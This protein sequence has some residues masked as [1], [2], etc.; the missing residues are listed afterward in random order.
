MSKIFNNAHYT[1]D[2]ISLYIVTWLETQ[3]LLK[4]YSNGQEVPRNSIFLPLFGEWKKPIKWKSSFL[5]LGLVINDVLSINR[6][7][8]YRPYLFLSRKL[9]SGLRHRQCSLNYICCQY[10]EH[11]GWRYFNWEC[12]QQRKIDVVGWGQGRLSMGL[13]SNRSSSETPCLEKIMLS[14]RDLLLQFLPTMLQRSGECI[15]W[16]RENGYSLRKVPEVFWLLVEDKLLT[17]LKLHTLVYL[18]S[19]LI[20]SRPSNNVNISEENKK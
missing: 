11:F 10:V 17:S 18:L 9:L 14:N 16:R 19:S 15:L 3:F 6:S 7:S 8:S 1:L 2:A 13:R 12:I 20:I 5:V 4:M